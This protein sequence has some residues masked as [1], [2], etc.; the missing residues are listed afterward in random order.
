LQDW[1]ISTGFDADAIAS[2]FVDDAS[3]VNPFAVIGAAFGI[4]SGTAFSVGPVSA[5]FTVL[6]GSFGIAASF[7]DQ[8]DDPE[9]SIQD[10]V[11]NYFSVAS[12]SIEDT[13]NNIFG[14][15]DYDVNA[16]PAQTGKYIF[17]SLPLFSSITIFI[18]YQ[19]WIMHRSLAN[20]WC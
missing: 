8:H 1:A 16:I 7:Y 11:S 9:A 3:G 17:L 2:D 6:S 20:V 18:S 12:Q 19:H 14:V 13:L 15:G 10:Q 4:A 5:G